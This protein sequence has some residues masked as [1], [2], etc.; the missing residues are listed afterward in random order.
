MWQLLTM[1]PLSTSLPHRAP[2]SPC[3]PLSVRPTSFIS[4]DVTGQ[5]A[6]ANDPTTQHLRSP[7]AHLLLMPRVQYVVAGAGG[8]ARIGEAA[9]QMRCWLLWLSS[10]DTPSQT[11]TPLPGAGHM[12]TASFRA[13]RKHN[14]SASHDDSPREH[15]GI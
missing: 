5:A 4:P 10:S 3:S 2:C 7:R 6:A 15:Q 14:H 11:R 1:G 13:V 9:W 8:D 12:S